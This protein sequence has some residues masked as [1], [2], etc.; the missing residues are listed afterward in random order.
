MEHC[1]TVK[2]NSAKLQKKTKKLKKICFF[3]LNE[4]LLCLSLSLECDTKANKFC[5][6]MYQ[7]SIISLMKKKAFN[8]PKKIM[9]EK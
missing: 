9:P 1:Y 8:I 3:F 4:K 6:R 5:C 2:N 7:I